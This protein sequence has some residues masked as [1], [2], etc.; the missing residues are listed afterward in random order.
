LFRARRLFQRN[1]S[2]PGET[3]LFLRNIT[4]IR[5][6]KEVSLLAISKPI[7][8]GK[9]MRACFGVAC[10]AA[11]RAILFPFAAAQLSRWMGLSAVVIAT[12]GNNFPI[13]AVS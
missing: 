12:L 8:Y 11:S 13:E 5:A 3:P 10:H 1:G 9:L 6:A 7:L 4:A 2:N